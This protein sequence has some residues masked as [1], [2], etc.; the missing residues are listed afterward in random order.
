MS[1]IEQELRTERFGLIHLNRN[2]A[3][4]KKAG[5]LKK[6]I[7]QKITTAKNEL[8]DAILNLQNLIINPKLS[9]KATLLSE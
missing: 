5:S 1:Y 2:L 9:G 3:V 6:L 7:G 8:L 4:F